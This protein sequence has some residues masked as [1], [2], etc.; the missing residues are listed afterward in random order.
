MSHWEG[1]AGTRSK[2]MGSASP[3]GI[4]ASCPTGPLKVRQ[5]RPWEICSL[6]GALAFGSSPPARLGQAQIAFQAGDYG[7]SSQPL[8]PAVG[9]PCRSP[10]RLPASNWCLQGPGHQDTGSPVAFF[11]HPPFGAL[12]TWG[13]IRARGSAVGQILLT[14]ETHGSRRSEGGVLEAP[15]EGAGGKW[16]AEGLENSP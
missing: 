4:S 1:R 2:Q 14:P 12:R 9:D 6:L 7:F 8:L 16:E 11:A 13:G 10:R 5:T 3:A 15:R